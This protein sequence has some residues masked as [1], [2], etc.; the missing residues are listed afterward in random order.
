MP[1]AY[2][3]QIRGSV[4]HHPE[5]HPLVGVYTGHAQFDAVDEDSPVC[6]SRP[7]FF[8]AEDVLCGLEGERHLEGAEQMA[9]FFDSPFKPSA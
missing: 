3:G 2:L 6:I 9:P 4:G 7:L 8:D 1:E 5:P